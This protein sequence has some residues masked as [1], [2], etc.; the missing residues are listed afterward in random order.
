MSNDYKQ[1]RSNYLAIMM[2]KT[3]NTDV[4]N[5]NAVNDTSYDVADMLVR[6]SQ[7]SAGLS[8]QMGTEVKE[9]ESDSNWW[10]RLTDTISESFYNINMGIYNFI[11]SFWDYGVNLVHSIG[12]IGDEAREKATSYDWQ[13]VATRWTELSTM[14]LPQHTWLDPDTYTSDFWTSLSN[15]EDASEWMQ[16]TSDEAYTNDFVKE[17]E[18]TAGQQA[19]PFVVGLFTGGAGSLALTGMN[20]VA[21]GF[22]ESYEDNQNYWLSS[23]YGT[24]EGLIEIGS[25]MIVGKV[26]DKIGA[27]ANKIGGYFNADGTK[28][29]KGGSGT[30]IGTVRNLVK[31]F[32]EEGLEEAAGALA[33][34]IAKALYKGGDA[35]LDDDGNIVY[36]TKDFWGLEGEGV[37]KQYLM[38]GTMG[39]IM[40]GAS[41]VATRYKYGSDGMK[42]LDYLSK[43]EEL[44]KEMTG[45]ARDT[46]QYENAIIEASANGAEAL[47]IIERMRGEYGKSKSATR[48]LDSLVE[49]LGGEKALQSFHNSVA[50]DT[51]TD[52]MAELTADFKTDFNERVGRNLFN[53][54]QEEMPTVFDGETKLEFADF[55]ADE[56]LANI[57]NKKSE[58]LVL[59]NTVYINNAYINE[60]I[61]G[62]ILHEYLGHVIGNNMTQIELD[63]VYNLIQ[64]VEGFDMEKYAK[65]Y[66]D[67]GLI[68]DSREFKLEMVNKFF[69]QSFNGNVKSFSKSL[70]GKSV[71][72]KILNVFDKSPE[73]KVR[74][75]WLKAL[76]NTIKT[77][78]PAKIKG[79]VN[80]FANPGSIGTYQD[81]WGSLSQ[82][83][84]NELE[85]FSLWKDTMERYNDVYEQEVYYSIYSDVEE[86]A[87]AVEENE[88]GER[89]AGRDGDGRGEWSSVLSTDEALDRAEQIARVKEKFT[90][91]GLKGYLETITD[92]EVVSTDY[93]LVP[94]IN[95]YNSE[96]YDLSGD[97]FVDD[98]YYTPEMRK[99]SKVANQ[100]GASIEFIA[101]DKKSFNF[102]GVNLKDGR[103]LINLPKIAES[104]LN[105]QFQWAIKHELTHAILK[106]N[107]AGKEKLIGFYFDKL[108]R[109]YDDINK[110]TYYTD[111]ILTVVKKAGHD[112][113]II[114]NY[115]T[116]VD[117]W[118]EEDLLPEKIESLKKFDTIGYNKD[119]A[120]TFIEEIVVERLI[121][122]KNH[123]K[124]F[125]DEYDLMQLAST[126]FD[127]SSLKDGELALNDVIAL[128]DVEPIETI[129][130][131]AMSETS[132]QT[133]I[134][135]FKTYDHFTSLERAREFLLSPNVW[136]SNS[137]MEK[138]GF[139]IKRGRITKL[140]DDLFEYLKE[141]SREG[142]IG[143][144][145]VL[146]KIRSNGFPD[147]GIKYKLTEM[148][149]GEAYRFGGVQFTFKYMDGNSVESAILTVSPSNS[150]M[151]KDNFIFEKAES[152]SHA[153]L[154]IV[155]GQQ[156]NVGGTMIRAVY[157]HDAVNDYFVRRMFASSLPE[158]Y[159]LGQGKKAFFIY[160]ANG[161][162]V[163]D[164]QIADRSGESEAT[165]NKRIEDAYNEKLKEIGKAVEAGEEIAQKVDEKELQTRIVVETKAETKSKE[166]SKPAKKTE[167]K[168][169]EKRIAKKTQVEEE[170]P[171]KMT[172]EQER[173]MEVKAKLLASDYYYYELGLKTVD[174]VAS[175]YAEDVKASTMPE[176]EK[177]EK[178]KNI[179]KA[180]AEIKEERKVDTRKVEMEKQ[181]KEAEELRKKAFEKDK[182]KAEAVTN[183]SQSLTQKSQAKPAEQT[184]ETQKLRKPRMSKYVRIDADLEALWKAV[185]ESEG[186]YA[187]FKV[188]D[189]QRYLTQ[190]QW[191]KAVEKLGGI[192]NVG[193]YLARLKA[194]LKE[195]FGT[196]PHNMAIANAYY[197]QELEA[198]NKAKEEASQK[199]EAQKN[200]DEFNE[201]QEKAL[202]VQKKGK[203]A[204]PTETKMEKT[205]EQSKKNR[206]TVDSIV[207]PFLF[208][209][210][211]ESNEDKTRQE[212][213]AFFT[214]KAEQ[215]S[216]LLGIEIAGKSD[217]LGSYTFESGENAG[218]AIN[219]VSYEF[220]L[221]DANGVQAQQFTFL[222]GDLGHEVQE[223]VIISKDSA[224][225]KANCLEL[226]IP[227]KDKAKAIEALKKLGINDY[228]FNN[229]EKSIKLL[230]FDTSVT[231]EQLMDKYQNLITELGDNY[232]AEKKAKYTPKQ[233]DMYDRE[234]RKSLYE[235]W[236]NSGKV[237]EE[238]GILRDLY[239]EAIRRIEESLS[240]SEK[241]ERIEKR[242]QPSDE[243]KGSFQ[244][245]MRRVGNHIKSIETE[246]ERIKSQKKLSRKSNMFGALINTYES[247]Y[248]FMSKAYSLI[249][250]LK[251]D[252]YAVSELSEQYHKKANELKNL[253]RKS[254]AIGE[255]I[256]ERLESEQL[257][258][259]QKESVA[260]EIKELNKETQKA[261]ELPQAPVE[262]A[263]TQTREPARQRQFQI[264][265]SAVI[266]NKM[267]NSS[268]TL[269][270]GWADA[271]RSTKIRLKGVKDVFIKT[272]D[273]NLP[274]GAE[275]HI[276]Y[277]K[278]ELSM[279]ELN[280]AQPISRFR[281]IDNI[282]K[283]ILE[284]KVKLADGT[285][286]R[287]ADVV[288]DDML[289]HLEEIVTRVID[290]NTMPTKLAEWTRRVVNERMKGKTK[291]E[292][293]K[294][295][296]S[297]ERTLKKAKRTTMGGRNVPS[298]GLQLYEKIIEH[299]NGM[300]DKKSII[301]FSE[302]VIQYYTKDSFG[303][304][305]GAF[306]MEL[307]PYIYQEAVGL[308]E[309]LSRLKR[310]QEVPVRFRQSLN[311]ILTALNGELKQFNRENRRSA[312]YMAER[313]VGYAQTVMAGTKKGKIRS[314][315][316]MFLYSILSPVNIFENE[317]GYDFEYTKLLR[318]E[319]RVCENNRISVMD[320]MKKTAFESLLKKAGIDNLQKFMSQKVKVKGV[321]VSMDVAL[322][323]VATSETYVSK[324]KSSDENT[325]MRFRTREKTTGITSEPLEMTVSDV[326]ELK[327][328]LPKGALNYL[329]MLIKD[330]Y[331]K[332]GRDYVK[333]K[334]SDITNGAS[335]EL[336][337]VYFP[338]RRIGD[339]VFTPNVA[340]RGVDLQ[341]FGLGLL[342][343][344]VN[345]NLDFDVSDGVVAM[346][347]RYIESI[348]Q[349]GE[350]AKWYQTKMIYDNTYVFGNKTFIQVM[351]ES[352]PAWDKLNDFI[353]KTALGVR[354]GENKAGIFNVLDRAVTGVQSA[355]LSGLFTQVKTLASVALFAGYFGESTSVKGFVVEKMNL[356]KQGII[357]DII[358]EYSPIL[359]TR[360][361]GNEAFEAELGKVMKSKVMQGIGT[362]VRTM[363]MALHTTYG[364]ACSQVQAEEEFGRHLF[365]DDGSIDR[366]VAKRTCQILEEASAKTQP[367]SLKFFAG[368]Y[369]AGG[370]GLFIKRLV[371]FAQSE[372]QAQAQM[373][374]DITIGYLKGVERTKKL[375]KRLA[376][377]DE[378]IKEL[379]FEKA[380][381]QKAVDDATD[382]REQKKAQ[383][384]VDDIDDRIRGNKNVR[385]TVEEQYE[386]HKKRYTKRNWFNKSVASYSGIILSS[387]IM[388]L[389]GSLKD[390]TFG[391]EDW[392][393]DDDFIESLAMQALVS[394][395]PYIGT[396]SYAIQNNTD[397]SM[398]TLDTINEVLD[399]V[400]GLV[401]GFGNGDVGQIT[402]GLISLLNTMGTMYGL[403]LNDA[404]KMLNGVWYNI[405]H[406]SNL[407]F[408][409]WLGVLN[410]TSLSSG[411]NDAISSGSTEKAT[412]YE[413]VYYGNYKFPISEDTAKGIVEAKADGGSVST[414]SIPDELDG[415]TLTKG[416]R[417]KFTIQY[418]KADKALSDMFLMSDYRYLTGGQK[419][420]AIN[421]I[422][423][424]Y[425]ESAKATVMNKAP[426]SRLAMVVYCGGDISSLAL[427]MSMLSGYGQKED[428][429]REINKIKGLTRK[430]KLLL[431]WVMGYTISDNGILNQVSGLLKIYEQS[432]A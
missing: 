169:Q 360:F 154:E 412:A 96:N 346:T 159:E 358:K 161:D 31:S 139:K 166:E 348:T 277:S 217:N 319:S 123:F 378:R 268:V 408:K 12:L 428:V 170:T 313:I 156:M 117:E 260:K 265:V 308:K 421:K 116:A 389:I 194:E 97:I 393:K 49:A 409:E 407:N 262:Q 396:I 249:I 199:T 163:G 238:G 184:Q 145:S 245:E 392:G 60:E 430:E 114:E 36:F 343:E 414:R 263:Q 287:F 203:K 73:A 234:S 43:N 311:N 21:S 214:K 418:R 121:G 143:C 176:P 98:W 33:E 102:R 367:T 301:A 112:T 79:I 147:V 67:M 394:W 298:N 333:A 257:T 229:D 243:Q 122:S 320:K 25:E 201:L 339:K 258:E 64:E 100:I 222:M 132:Y 321:T 10:D 4:G 276:D 364:F 351:R 40:A 200:V 401:K 274:V 193:T 312:V 13:S 88:N 171:E 373:I 131:T 246:I 386:K 220:N 83:E 151:Y 188:A 377:L 419:A 399:D 72:Q 344:R 226:L 219:E 289:G 251:E 183:K 370:E 212:V 57:E 270:E 77:F 331:G 32:N 403:P 130:D 179:E 405:D 196:K 293:Y 104:K 185:K 215:I 206:K 224:K 404:W 384:K 261:E 128:K 395:V 148:E 178:L 149:G 280:L 69:Q 383:E 300:M 56:R 248:A 335:I 372:G 398:F 371:G 314:L 165:V 108:K 192:Q 329:D 71:I 152:G 150:P 119:L 381:A 294:K 369:R 286:V 326:S 255:R 304:M 432:Q 429:I 189:F 68:R 66:E 363:D 180:L 366:E 368:S 118:G 101:V 87:K 205:S 30:I 202:E 182:V 124:K 93:T 328:S 211:N 167:S 410:E 382:F 264:R 197:R 323:I 232:D 137:P 342:I 41:D 425:Y 420:T 213:N 397:L 81:V 103:I 290:D 227:V 133:E 359:Y 400:Q 273:G 54:L 158:G 337:D 237:K 315:G 291:L 316:K 271:N 126:E 51:V 376:E 322:Q 307:N 332:E 29:S 388:V 146:N 375:G 422:T 107:L 1:T 272:I 15:P 18:V 86:M 281:V 309:G 3:P 74:K 89:G 2:G 374:Y 338:T 198:Y 210:V 129:S 53:K 75:A 78:S 23:M 24:A 168:K 357:M 380:E 350:W 254:D 413:T 115:L 76:R 19:I 267:A 142:N 109:I 162:R 173:Y 305:L 141:N 177:Q 62:T 190:E 269:V 317:F 92:K 127:E 228:T 208:N 361:T 310:G 390:W 9:E 352:I 259:S 61:R 406:E 99:I 58:G 295:V 427:Y 417:A 349:W 6:N 354:F 239:L 28:V 84:R 379:E 231:Q 223:N 46:T 426:T 424:A 144:E 47:E 63:N 387:I 55:D 402:N 59:G 160:D 26:L 16:K 174:E 136:G 303:K 334:Y 38:G 233:S 70:F 22:N 341:T 411:V 225:S 235:K 113:A 52:F 241:Q 187:S 91:K 256:K 95:Q 20:A 125:E 90:R 283:A 345:N 353:N 296:T 299:L 423:N 106:K 80:K 284:T 285:N 138:S 207:A 306:G 279:K 27:G 186:S 385:E 140:P 230:E 252:G 340:S 94:T 17:L 5:I 82:K 355:V 209:P 7:Q 325:K 327:S 45:V 153:K 34:P 415:V 292:T 221:R 135:S 8:S 85:R 42:V 37:A 275:C 318:D 244:Y 157:R 278:V 365:K 120:R 362:P 14:V 297:I 236:A 48:H 416:E 134:D 111:E 253:K 347:N 164:F 282:K 39:A 266:T 431:M 247:A 65:G 218:K 216:G 302:D 105:N 324:L 44:A 191:D 11:D 204:I 172:P 35:F 242:I 391:R 155:E 110:S 330:F 175:K 50:T 195:D 336:L 356:S 288:S 250:Q 181:A 240:Q